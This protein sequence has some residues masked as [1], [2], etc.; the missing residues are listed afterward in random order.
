MINF[1]IY[2][3]V[4]YVVHDIVGTRL[5]NQAVVVLRGGGGPKVP[6]PSPSQALKF[7]YIIFYILNILSCYLILCYV[8]F[9]LV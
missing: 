3:I 7:W 4:V 8:L 6:N 1:L 9:L 5:N 2:M